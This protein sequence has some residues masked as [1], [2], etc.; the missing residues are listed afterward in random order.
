MGKHY[1]MSDIHGCFDE[2]LDALE[3]IKFSDDDILYILGD[4]VDRGPDPIK[5]LED[6]MYRPNIIP[7]IGNHDLIA[8]IM[9]K[10]TMNVTE[11]E[12][13]EELVSEFQDWIADGGDTTIKEFKQRTPQEQEYILEFLSE[14]NTFEEITIKGR[15][16]IMVHGGLE[17]FEP[18]KDLYDYDVVDLISS[19]PDYD[20]PYFTDKYTIT[21]HTPT[22][23][24]EGNNGTIIRKNNHIAIDCGCVSGHNLAVF[25]LETEEE[26]YVPFIK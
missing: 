10:K 19:R 3:L 20:K 24:Q 22:V 6:M 11:D 26:F 9:L 16:Y 1:V 23:L 18:D 8:L 13:N 4:C 2:Y 17:P 7:I 5:V 15:H 25:C 14:F 12:I 21:G